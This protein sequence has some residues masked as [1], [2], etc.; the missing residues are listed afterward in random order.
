MPRFIAFLRAINVGGHTVKMADLRKLFEDLG[1]S[2]V[3]TFIASG[4]VIFETPSEDA[5]A[6]EDKIERHLQQSLGYG[7][8]TFLRSSSELAAIAE[9][10][11]FSEGELAG[12]GTL[13]YI[14]FLSASPTDEAQRKLAGF[15]TEVDDFHV[16]RREV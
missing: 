10:S 11:P 3:E 1:F 16:H 4:N 13:I 8:A 6:L 14:A 9:Y 7:V 15:K 5:K 2:N 12:E